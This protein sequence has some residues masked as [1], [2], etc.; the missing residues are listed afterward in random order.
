MKQAKKNKSTP[1]M[2]QFWS[3]KD[4]HKDCI[5]LF[6]MGDFYETFEKDAEITS[7]I[8]GIALTKRANGAA[9]SVALAGFPYHSLEQHLYKLLKAG[10]KVAICEQMED[11]SQTK[12][13]VKR[14]VVE[15]VS[16]GMNVSE[17]F[18]D[19]NKNNYICSLF[20]DRIG[21][22][23]SILDYSTGEFY[24]NLIEPIDL[25]NLISKYDISELIIIEDH[26][27]IFKKFKSL[28]DLYTNTVPDWVNDFEF[29]SEILCN[30]FNVKSLKGFGLKDKNASIISSG[31]LIHYLKENFTSTAPHIGNLKILS[32]TDVMQLD[33]YTIKNLE[34]FESLLNNNKKKGTFI[35]SIDKTITSSGSRLLKKWISNPL[36]DKRL[37]DNRL[38]LVEEFTKDFEFIAETREK[39]KTT[40]DIDRIL[41]KISCNKANPSDLINLAD[42]LNFINLF[43]LMISDDKKN[44]LSLITASSNTNNLLS[45]IDKTLKKEPAINPKKGNF[46]NDGFSKELDELRKISN[47][48]NQWML[49]YQSK[50]KDETAIS[51]LKIKFNKIFGYYID[52]TKVHSDKV[53][54][55]FIKKQTLVNNERYFTEELKNFEHKILNAEH[56]ILSLE[57]NIFNNLCSHVLRFI[58]EIQKNSS[59]ISQIDIFSSFGYISIKNN[60][61][62]PKITENFN[63]KIKNG[64]H[65]VIEE[66]FMQKNQFISNDSDLNENEYLSIIT[67]PNMAGKSTY[68]RQIGLIVIMAQIGSNIP[69]DH[70]EIGIV[71]KLFTRVG[72]SDNL[73]EGEST[74]LVEMQ[75]TANIVNN[76]TQ[77]SLIILD[78]IG[79][80]TSTYDGL[81]IAWA[82]TEY[83]HNHIKAKTLFATHYHELVGLANDLESAN[84]LNVLVEESSGKSD[85]VFLRK[86][87]KGGT[88]K[89]YGIYV[90]KMAGLP[91]EIISKSK[92][93]LELLTSKQNS[94]SLIFNKE[95]KSIINDLEDKKINVSKD[96]INDLNQIKI[97]DISPLE[98]LNILNELIKKYTN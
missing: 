60:Y 95:I 38:D 5:I 86:I 92:I 33:Y 68:L 29:N 12:G 87:V 43:R 70:A 3:I 79:R 84:N 41:S 6:R 21:I 64:R 89:S 1:V 59:I 47:D 42:S 56:E 69:A 36:T 10:N 15:I 54:D 32:Y 77:S 53:P 37:I 50:L 39:L 74:F 44:L 75:E 67:G 61:T 16:P 13:I 66:M 51:S 52:V 96:F 90:A 91:N 9:A 20:Y 27:K 11:A 82:V 72:A 35:S 83:L 7:E 30:H 28:N 23:V 76:A 49:D 17:K 97:N 94:K 55:Y 25:D 62:R 58:S 24:T 93:Y 19:G 34:I 31:M 8:L 48:A 81:S 18:L 98:G 14:E 71:D 4:Q 40:Y 88:D 46:I 22:G 78:E 85:I 73:A 45:E 2:Q 63:L 80:G 65:P 57:N 26:K